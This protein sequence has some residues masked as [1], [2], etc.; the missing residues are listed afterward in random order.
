VPGAKRSN[1]HIFS[2]FIFYFLDILFEWGDSEFEMMGCLSLRIREK[3]IN[4]EKLFF[5]SFFFTQLQNRKKK[6]RRIQGNKKKSFFF[7]RNGR[8]YITMKAIN[9]HSFLC[10]EIKPK[11]KKENQQRTCRTVATSFF[12][13]FFHPLV[14]GWAETTC[15]LSLHFFS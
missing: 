5:F 4:P 3:E 13:F 8:Y 14:I 11:K 10:L 1:V 15:L 6:N 7:I 9:F 12:F 2:L